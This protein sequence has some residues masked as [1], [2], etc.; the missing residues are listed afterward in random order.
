MKIVTKGQNNMNT[1]YLKSCLFIILMSCSFTA[2][3][4]WDCDDDGVLDNYN[5]YQNNGSITAAILVDGDNLV[6]SGDLFAAFVDGEQRGA[7]DLTE[8]PFGPYAGT[9]QFLTLIYSNA[10]SGET[11]T[12]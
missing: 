12:Y 8:V 1:S 3:P 11:I 10:A 4:N 9:F 2:I 7:G 5:D 6:S